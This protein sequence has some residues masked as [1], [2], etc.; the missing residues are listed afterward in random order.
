LWS[1]ATEC[2]IYLL[3]PIIVWAWRRGGKVPVILFLSALSPLP[4]QYFPDYW[5]SKF[6]FLICYLLGCLAADV[7]H[8]P[9]SDKTFWWRL[10]WRDIALC[11]STVVVS[12][13][14]YAHGWALGHTSDVE[15]D[16]FVAAVTCALLVSMGQQRAGRSVAA[17]VLG[18]PIFYGLGL[19]S[20]S[21]YLIQQPLL[22]IA[23]NHSARLPWNGDFPVHV[24]FAFCLHLPLL[25][26]CSYVF[27]L[28]AERPFLSRGADRLTLPWPSVLK[29][30]EPVFVLPPGA[31]YVS[32]AWV[33]VALRFAAASF[34]WVPQRLYRLAASG[35]RI[36]VGTLVKI[37][38]K[39]RTR[40]ASKPRPKV[41]LWQRFVDA[42]D[43]HE[44]PRQVEARPADVGPVAPVSQDLVL[45]SDNREER[46]EVDGLL[47]QSG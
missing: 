3:M 5:Y 2:Q 35:Y 38:Y 47:G 23:F 13:M 24:Y 25:L 42:V 17:N 9:G 41:S 27:Y 39:A 40:M 19:M 4:H 31:K 14:T 29:S 21:M 7:V 28:V 36:V 44:L 37:L 22:D 33:G 20:Y 15:L 12:V 18:S 26:L 43:D 46:R 45:D 8:R 11:G 34:L 16:V 10:P 1:I 32:F 30:A 6:H